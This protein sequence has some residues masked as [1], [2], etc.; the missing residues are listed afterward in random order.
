MKKLLGFAF[1]AG[2]G[3]LAASLW[4]GD[5]AEATDR[6]KDEAQPAQSGAKKV[7]GDGGVAP[8]PSTP[9]APPSTGTPAVKGD[10][11]AMK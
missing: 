6:Q 4:S 9:K 10:A 5:R 8:S 1:L 3:L 2:I 11:G 7:K